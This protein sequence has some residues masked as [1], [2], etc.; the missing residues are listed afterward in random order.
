MDMSD[1]EK[2]KLLN[3]LGRPSVNDPDEAATQKRVHRTAKHDKA[4][5]FLRGALQQLT[6][7]LIALDDSQVNLAK[8]LNGVIRDTEEALFEVN[9]TR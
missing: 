6:L 7:A 9:G 2:R 5:V 3:G 8:H 4:G 1:D